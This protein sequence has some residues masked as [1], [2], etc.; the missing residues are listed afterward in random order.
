MGPSNLRA[1]V[2]VSDDGKRYSGTFTQ[3]FYDPTGKIVTSSAKGVITGT[4]I[5]VDSTPPNIF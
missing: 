4:R 1:E 3:D 2:T 5:T